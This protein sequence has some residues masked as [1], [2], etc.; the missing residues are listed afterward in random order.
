MQKPKV[1]VICLCYNQALFV[2]ESL[3][4]V[5]G[6]DYSD[7]EVIVVDDASTDGSAEVIQ[8]FLKDYPEVP[9]LALKENV[10]NT[11]AFNRGLALAS[12]QYVID[13][14]CDDVMLSK[15]VSEQVAFWDRVS[16]RVGVVYSEAEYID[17]RGELLSYHFADGKHEPYNGEVYERLI[18]TYFIPP[19]TMMMRK[20]VLDELGGYDESLAYEDFDFWVRS[21]RHW[22]YAYQ[23]DMLTRIRRLKYSHSSGL[24]Q[25][26]DRQLQS[27]V[28]ICYKIAA[29]NISPEE[30]QALVRRIQYEVRHAFLMGHREEVAQL[31]ALMK[32]LRGNTWLYRV[33]SYLNWGWDLSI[34]RRLIHRFKY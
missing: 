24:Y 13:L 2:R 34:V 14:A 7:L 21:A 25:P 28:R 20:D 17:E 31:M 23:P 33:I 5:M 27:T 12:G 10:G 19:P 6:Q 9:F 32:T 3:D 1:S 16:D 29:M 26:G 15:R 4:S 8:T 18:D 11:T 22:E 30:D